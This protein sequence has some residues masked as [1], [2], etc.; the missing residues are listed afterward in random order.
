MA[1]Y[2]NGQGQNGT[3][4]KNGPLNSFNENIHFRNLV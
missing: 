3:I 1:N 2:Q 4:Y